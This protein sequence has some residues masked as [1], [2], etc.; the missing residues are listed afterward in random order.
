[1]TK[2]KKRK[3]LL[4]AEMEYEHKSPF[5]TLIQILWEGCSDELIE[6]QS[7]NRSVVN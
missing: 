7:K 2:L 1:M 3:M 6:I 5:K 4:E